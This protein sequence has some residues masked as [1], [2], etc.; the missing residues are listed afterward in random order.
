MA[1]VV[2][3]LD[4]TLADTS[5]DL[6][7]AANAAL[8]LQMPLLLTGEAGCG[9][10]D[11]AWAAADDWGLVGRSRDGTGQRVAAKSAAV[12]AGT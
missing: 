8:A 12:L 9:K 11:F 1:T 10:T 2:F 7:A 4:G 3:D 6:I 5:G